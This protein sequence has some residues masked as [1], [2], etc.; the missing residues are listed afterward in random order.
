MKKFVAIS[1]MLAF[2]FAMSAMADTW[3]GVISDS[4]CGAAHATKMNAKCV[5][6]CVKGGQAPV[7]VSDG[8]VLKIDDASKEK[9]MPH[10]GHK[11]KVTGTEKDGTVMIES[12][13]MAS[14]S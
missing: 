2:V 9:V 13:E 1:M 4:K 11:V 14:G 3:T 5:E 8:K 6:S 7:L 12:I 10:L